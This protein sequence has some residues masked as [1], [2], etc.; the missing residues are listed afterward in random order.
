M[1]NFNWTPHK[2]L[3]RLRQMNKAFYRDVKKAATNSP[4]EWFDFNLKTE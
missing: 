2:W 3:A 4:R 1:P